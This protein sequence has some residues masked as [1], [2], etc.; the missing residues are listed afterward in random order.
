MGVSPEVRQL[1]VG[2]VLLKRALADLRARGV[3]M[4]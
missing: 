3:D 1:G 2:T 4:A